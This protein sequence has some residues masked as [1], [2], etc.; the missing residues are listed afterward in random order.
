M[1]LI[2]QPTKKLRLTHA[3]SEPTVKNPLTF[4]RSP[5]LMKDSLFEIVSYL[6]I[7]K[8]IELG[9]INRYFNIQLSFK[10]YNKNGNIYFKRQSNIIDKIIY[11]TICYN[12]SNLAGWYLQNLNLEKMQRYFRKRHKHHPISSKN[13]SNNDKYLISINRKKNKM[14][15]LFTTLLSK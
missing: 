9:C 1:N 12:L 3:V 8:I 15:Y 11:N 10:F 13:C 4:E 6:H 7:F 14:L 2:Q 5:L